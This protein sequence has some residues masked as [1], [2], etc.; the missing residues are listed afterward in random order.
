MLDNLFELLHVGDSEIRPGIWHPSVSQV[1]GLI[2]V[3]QDTNHT[4]PSSATDIHSGNV[5]D[6]DRFFGPAG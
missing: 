1:V 2:V 5:T 6:E 3:L 4:Q